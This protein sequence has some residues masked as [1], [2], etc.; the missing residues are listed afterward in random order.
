VV[1]CRGT[2]ITVH[3]AARKVARRISRA[4]PP[5][6]KHM[7]QRSLSRAITALLLCGAFATP[8]AFAQTHSKHHKKSTTTESTQSATTSDTG[9]M[10]SD[11]STTAGT[12]ASDSAA[13]SDQSTT[14]QTNSSTSTPATPAT[15]YPGQGT[16]ATP[17][18][19]ATPADAAAASMNA[20]QLSWNDLDTD[21][22]GNLSK[23]EAGAL[24]SLS[25]VFDTADGNKDGS[26][27]ADEYRAYLKTQ[28]K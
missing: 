26:L 13:M 25:Q 15:P 11:T 10:S 6:H 18:T 23:T 1:T 17:A 28:G 9:T 24:S 20:K 12:T 2:V 5:E 21:H 16:A 4:S 27:T 8:L 7:K 19:P 3:P 14:A 22:D